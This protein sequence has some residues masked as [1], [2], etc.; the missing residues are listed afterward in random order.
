MNSAL[1]IVVKVGSNVVFPNSAMHANALHAIADEVAYLWRQGHHIAVVSSGAVGCGNILFGDSLN[2]YEGV[3]RDQT[4]AMY[5]QGVLMY[6]WIQALG[7]HGIAAGQLLRVHADFESGH[8]PATDFLRFQFNQQHKTNINGIPIIN[9][10]D[11]MA[12]A[13]IVAMREHKGDNDMLGALVS[14]AVEADIYVIVTDVPAVC[15][16]NPKQHADALVIPEIP[17][18]D[19]SVLSL[20]DPHPKDRPTGLRTK[21]LAAKHLQP[22][23]I[24][25]HI[26]GGET[27][28]ILENRL[29]RQVVEGVQIGT[30]IPGW[31]N[32][33]GHRSPAR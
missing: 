4:A 27:D 26:I 20:V 1:R 18:V 15:D 22:H 3:Q 16:R 7:K 32:K 33:T 25:T 28:A 5:G 13:E 31:R 24:T 23:G 21:L 12:T 29:I 2:A 10:E 11:T 14:I 8:S 19:D 30:K 9:E 6:H 17:V